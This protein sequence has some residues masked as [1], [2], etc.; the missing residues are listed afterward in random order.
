[1]KL[2]I[3]CIFILEFGFTISAKEY[4]VSLSG[5][6]NN[7]GSKSAPFLSIQ[8]ALDIV[9]PGDV[10]AVEKGKYYIGSGLTFKQ[11]K[12]ILRSLNGGVIL[13]GNFR[14]TNIKFIDIKL[15][16]YCLIENL[17]VQNVNGWGIW[18]DGDHNTVKNCT[19]NYTARDGINIIGASYNII[20]GNYVANTGNDKQKA[21]SITI[22]GKVDKNCNF[23][24]ADFNTIE[25]NHITR[26]RTHFGVNFLVSYE[27]EKDCLYNKSL[28]QGNIVRFN[29]IDS[30]WSGIYS[31]QH[32]GFEF[33]GNLIRYAEGLG[34]DHE[35]HGI[36]LDIKDKNYFAINAHGKIYNNTIAF[37]KNIGLYNVNC[38]NIEIYNNAFYQVNMN[39]NAGG[40]YI[41]MNNTEGIKLSNNAYYGSNV[42]F[43]W[44]SQKKDTMEWKS[45]EKIFYSGKANI[46]EKNN[47]ALLKG[48]GLNLAKIN[49]SFNSSAG[50]NDKKEWG[51]GAAQ[52]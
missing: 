16:S 32:K 1:M 31:R 14:N 33:Y 34:K 22:E 29:T 47:R 46:L 27:N 39:S 5:N 42:Y 30:C 2:F 51:I 44:V 6:D 23:T 12:I 3:I 43:N 41:R 24:P 52:K 38:T 11:N 10:I 21:N 20:S 8:K 19:V 7:N 28:I 37:C 45:C 26:N 49:A 35:G 9:K 50:M 13:D 40:G 4:Y 36:K 48:K 17:I 25:Y 18:I 15:H